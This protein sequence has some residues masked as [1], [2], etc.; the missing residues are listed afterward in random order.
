MVDEYQDT[1][2]LQ[3]E[4]IRLLA[5]THDNVA[6]V[7][8]DA[9]SIYSFRGADFRNIMDFPK[10]FPGTRIIKFEENYRSTQ[11]ILNRHQRDHQP[12]P[13]KATRSACSRA[14]ASAPG[15]SWSRPAANRCSR[16][17]SARKILELREA[18]RAAMGHGGVVPLEFSFLRPGNRAGARTTFH[19]S[20]GAAFSSWT[21]PMSKICWRICAIIANPQDA[22][23]WNRVLMLHEGIGPG[24]SQKVIKWLLEGGNAVERLRSYNAKGKIAQGLRTLAQVLEEAAKAEL[25]SEQAQY[26]MQY[27]L[28]I[29]K[30]HYPDDHPRASAGHGT[31]PEHDRALSQPRTAAQRHGAGTAQR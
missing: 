6:V 1:N 10:H 15:P 24:A 27:Y 9:Q 12:A 4:I 3:A 7:G 11:P 21:R 18:R 16:S 5:A 22:V 28:P 2:H 20:N 23:S 13:R 14:K 17:S 30:Q 8:D 25:P 26:L 19:S 29:L 31:L